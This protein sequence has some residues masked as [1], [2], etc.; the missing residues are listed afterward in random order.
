MSG[1]TCFMK[2]VLPCDTSLDGTTFLTFLMIEDGGIGHGS[3]LFRII[4]HLLATALY[5]L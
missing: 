1:H 4:G 3:M 2:Y 5:L